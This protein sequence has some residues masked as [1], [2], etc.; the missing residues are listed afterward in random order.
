MNYKATSPHRKALNSM[1]E[2]V[3]LMLER[4]GFSAKDHCPSLHQRCGYFLES[5]KAQAKDG[6]DSGTIQDRADFRTSQLAQDVRLALTFRKLWEACA[7]IDGFL[8][9]GTAPES[10]PFAPRLSRQ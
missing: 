9:Y 10:N 8:D 2:R 1:R 5:T 4:N 6:L 7:M 3:A